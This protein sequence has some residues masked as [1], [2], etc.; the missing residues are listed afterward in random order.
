M[1][2]PLCYS[3][4]SSEEI[5]LH[6]SN[7]S[8]DDHDRPHFIDLDL[9]VDDEADDAMD[10]GEEEIPKKISEELLQRRLNGSTGVAIKPAKDGWP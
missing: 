4:F 8:G 2:F 6:A 10:G 7:C 3:I 5:E 9:Q 1:G